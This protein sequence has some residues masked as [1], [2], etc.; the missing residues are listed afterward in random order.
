MLSGASPPGP[1]TRA[2]VDWTLR[3]GRWIWLV[4]LLLAVPATWR[5]AHLYLGL[6][7]DV[8]ELL[9]R[10]S[11]SVRA[12]DELRVRMPGLQYLGVVVDVGDAARLPQGERLIDDL[13]A[14]IRSYPPELARAVR[15]GTREE[16]E[17]LETHA[18]L[19]VDL[20]DLASIRAR[21]EA[22]RDYEVSRETGSALDDDAPPPPLA[23]DDIEKKYDTRLPRRSAHRGDRYSSEEEHL[24]MLL[25]E[26][27]GYETGSSHARALLARV[28]SDIAALGGAAAYAP[29]MRIG[30]AGDVAISVEELD[31][32]IADLSLSSVLVLVAVVAAIIAYY[33]WGASVVILVAPLLLA[34]VYAFAIASLPPFGVTELNSNT[35]FMGSIIVGNGINFGL[36][37]LARYVE[38]RRRG[39]DVRDALA[40]AVGSARIGTFAAALGAGVSYASLVSTQFRG[41]RQFGIIGGL[42]MVLSWAVAF[43]CMPP[44]IAWLDGH[45]RAALKPRAETHLLGSVARFVQR[46]PVPV[47]AAGLLLTALAVPRVAT[48]SMDQVESDFSKLRRKDTWTKGEGYWGARMDRVLG[49]YLTPTVVLADSPEQAQAIAARLREESG[50]PPLGPMI[51]EVRTLQDVLPAEQPAKIA[52]ARAIREDMTPKMRALLDPQKR[53]ELDRLLGSD[54]LQPITLAGLPR[55]FTTGLLERDGSAGR[56]VLVFP[57]PSK[58]LWEGPPLLSFV[59]GLRRAASIEGERPGRVAGSLPLSS[60]ILAS[61]RHDGPIASLLAFFGVLAVVLVIFRGKAT[62]F[63]VIASLT[64]GALW[65]AAAT[66]VLGVKINFA[67]FIAF[68]ITFGIGVDYAVNVMSRYVQDGQR[69]VVGTI[70][71]TGSAVALCS[72]TTIIG[73]SSLLVAENRALYLFGFVAVLGE[74]ACLTA[75]LTLL[76]AVLVLVERHRRRAPSAGHAGE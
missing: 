2:F 18:P 69:D 40:V 70:R 30:Y 76:P 71:S 3:Y 46:F 47:A 72:L 61:I 43:V 62:G 50:R 4:A 53:D 1:R 45:T 24:T 9:P 65:L 7:S 8:E 6:K 49:S 32:L 54:D 17:F 75:A 55:T 41:F 20:A 14:R 15:V 25:V 37:L 73:Y 33:R 39:Q 11:P 63:Y 74:I 42:G 51:S 29:G 27:G 68:P 13:A 64:I 31:A 57:R 19:Y 28:K 35:A 44:L 56:T 67:N 12:L 34:T 26:V 16:R 10:E 38:Q 58:E 36:M 5:T 59:S 60:D 22:R 23:F 21:I 48:F 66:M 52:E